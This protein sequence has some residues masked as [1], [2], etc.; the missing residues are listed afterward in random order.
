M[1][2][3]VG[4]VDASAEQ[5]ERSAIDPLGVVQEGEPTL[6]EDSVIGTLLRTHAPSDTVVFEKEVVTSG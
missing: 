3:D 6:Q 1:A 4:D 5:P 2:D